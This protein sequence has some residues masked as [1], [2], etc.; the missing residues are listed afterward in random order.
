MPT[1][2]LAPLSSRQ[3]QVLGFLARLAWE[4]SGAAGSCDDW[5]HAEVRRT[6][7]RGRLKECL[8]EDFLPL[9]AHFNALIGNMDVAFKASLKS[10]NEPRSW[11]M[12]C[13]YREV[14]AVKDV[15]PGAMNYAR[16]FLHKQRN[17]TLEEAGHNEIWHAIFTIRRKAQSLRKKK[18]GGEPAA[19]V[20]G[21][22]LGAARGARRPDPDKEPF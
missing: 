19:D 1:A 11:D 8:N 17:V 12:F 15:L 16:G 6:V 7:R 10:I 13:L 20:L 2:A 14:T 9:A 18:S 4:E 21:K 5:R 22:L 3:R